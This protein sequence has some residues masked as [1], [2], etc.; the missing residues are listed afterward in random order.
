MRRS[1]AWLE[2]FRDLLHLTR[3]AGRKFWGQEISSDSAARYVSVSSCPKMFNAFMCFMDLYIS[4]T[5]VRVLG[6]R[7]AQNQKDLQVRFQR[8]NLTT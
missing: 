3:T 1:Q 5:E 6:C 8:G 2:R 4:S 7:V